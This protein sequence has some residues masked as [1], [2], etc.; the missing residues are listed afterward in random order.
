V[1]RYMSVSLDHYYHLAM[2]MIDGWLALAG[3]G[4][5]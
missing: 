2:M 1:G 3:D 5:M 4:V